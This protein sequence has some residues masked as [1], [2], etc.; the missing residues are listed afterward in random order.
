MVMTL[1][2]HETSVELGVPF[3]HCDPLGVV[4]HGRYFEYLEHARTALLERLALDGAELV[5]TGYR[6]WVA[7]A[8][9]RH[10]SPLRY[11][12]R[13]RVTAW[14]REWQQRIW[15]SYDV[16]DLTTSRQAARA[17]TVLVVTDADGNL[18]FEV[19]EVIRARIDQS[20]VRTGQP[21]PS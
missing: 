17:H 4:W 7:D 10:V 12:D 13:V 19:P 11:R 5:A 3:H 8:R 16:H 6:F 21:Q 1:R 2:A 20:L 18:Q 9:C 14:L 15:V